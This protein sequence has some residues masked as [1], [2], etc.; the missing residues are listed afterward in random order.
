[1]GVRYRRYTLGTANARWSTS[2]RA[3]SAH[4]SLAGPL[5]DLD[6]AGGAT[7]PARAPL[8][9]T[10]ERTRLSLALH[11]RG[12]DLAR[13]LTAA[14]YPLPLAGRLDANALIAGDY[15]ALDLT[16]DARL[17][18]GRFGTIAID[19]A[20][21]A[22]HASH[23]RVTLDRAQL[24]LAGGEA[25]LHGSFGLAHGA[26]LA[27]E[28]DAQSA[29]LG[30]LSQTLARSLPLVGRVSLVARVSGTR[31]APRVALTL[32]GY[33]IG[34]THF[35]IASV[36]AQAHAERRLLSLDALKIPLAQ[37]SLFATGSV[38]L[39]PR[40]LR[41]ETDA[42]LAFAARVDQVGLAQFSALAP[43]GTGL[44]GSLDGALALG[45]DVVH[46]SLGG[47]LALTGGSFVGPAERTPIVGIVGSLVF[48]GS[49][50]H[51]ENARAQVAGGTLAL[52][53]SASLPS[54]RA[55]ARELA[56]SLDGSAQDATLDVPSY[57][58]GRVNGTLSLLR[59][60]PARPQLSGALAFDSTRI[61][62]AALYNPNASANSPPQRL[63]PLD[64]DLLVTAGND[65]RVQNG[66]VDV[67][68]QGTLAV[69]GTL[70]APTLAGTLTSS[71]G[72]TLSFY[73]TFR[74]TAGT[75]VFAAK[76]GVFPQVDARATTFVANPPTEVRLHVTGLAPNLHVALS[77]DP[78][79]ARDQIL[80]LVVGAQAL[81]AVGGLQPGSSV[82][83]NP[84]TAAAEGQLGGL[85]ARNLLDPLGAQLGG[86]LGLQNFA[87]GYEP[88]GGG[89]DISAKKRLFGTVD[90]VYAQSFS[91]PRRT[92]YGLRASPNAATALQLT[93]FSQPDANQ[94]APVTLS[95]ILT[96]NP[97]V[98]AAEPLNGTSGFSF[99]LQRKYP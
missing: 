35:R 16:S 23:G 68:G 54:L 42:P 12:L 36:T 22:A 20:K 26:P 98:S 72:G 66:A 86:A 58:R 47:T 71:G 63:P 2:G 82:A 45:G 62:L 69:G 39:D 6:V 10:L 67:A 70:A 50:A 15:P 14:E 93:F 29:D 49:S 73:R 80:G 19:D 8:A 37:G 89:F 94:L 92:S 61:P 48:F 46:P 91:F 76:D 79:Y 60:P 95:G 43:K 75:L 24:A 5:G 21:L 65:V 31:R 84:L 56:F 41:I 88:A 28:L 97:A 34:T 53:G 30:L 55:P 78:P 7:L 38:P 18:D 52:S 81:G 96:S 13:T 99:S 87:V 51:L 11:A 17:R 33:D 77:S 3:L 74:L 32:H 83:V 27:L 85:L 59:T 40:T 9:R 57:F 1:S 25:Q 44:G 64:L 90:A 4:V